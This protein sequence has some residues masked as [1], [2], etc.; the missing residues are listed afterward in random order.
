MTWD[1]HESLRTSRN[2]IVLKFLEENGGG[3][4]GMDEL[5][6]QLK[7]LYPDYF[8]I[9][10]G[11]AFRIFLHQHMVRPGLVKLENAHGATKVVAVVSSDTITAPA[12]PTGTMPLIPKISLN[13]RVMTRNPFVVANNTP[14]DLEEIFND[15]HFSNV[16]LGD[17]KVIA[18]IKAEVRPHI[19]MIIQ[20]AKEAE[21]A[22]ADKS[23]QIAELEERIRKM[24][25]ELTAITRQ[26]DGWRRKY[27]ELNGEKNPIA[28]ECSGAR[29]RAGE[30]LVVFGERE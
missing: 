20:R 26:C 18:H 23:K 28:K 5:F 19:M 14:D 2:K 25:D 6:S 3:F 24:G 30:N 1:R 21:S 11:S 10:T 13:K 15:M 9:N 4:E 27:E 29:I 8:K 17:L 12:E 7:A 22:L 16:T